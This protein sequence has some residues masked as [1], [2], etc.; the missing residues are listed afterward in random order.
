MRRLQIINVYDA[1]YES[2]G[3]FWPHVHGRII[4]ALILKH[5]TLIG[6]FLIKGPVAFVKTPSGGSIKSKILRYVRD[7]CSSTPFMIALPVF[8][9]VFHHYCKKRFE[10]AF[11][12][13]PLEV[14]HT[15]AFQVAVLTPFIF[16]T[17]CYCVVCDTCVI[18]G[19]RYRIARASIW[20]VRAFSAML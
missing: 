20:P 14:N 19:A 1:E 16:V 17:H 15:Q 12:N 8:T 7:S 3:A 4:A 5:V 18:C 2:A 10:P 9:L 13:Y 6:I 11:T